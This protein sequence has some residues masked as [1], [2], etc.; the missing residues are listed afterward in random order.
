MNRQLLA[1]GSPPPSRPNSTGTYAHAHLPCTPNPYSR[2]SAE[3][4]F[5]G[6]QALKALGTDPAKAVPDL[7]PAAESAPHI[8]LHDARFAASLAAVAACK[9]AAALYTAAESLAHAA[10]A[11]PTAVADVHAAVAT[12]ATLKA[13][14]I[15]IKTP[16]LSAVAPLF[17][18][19]TH[20][21]GL[22][23]P[24]KSTKLP[25]FAATGQAYWTIAHAQTLG[26][27]LAT[28]LE[29][30]V[31]QALKAA[32]PD[33][34]LWTKGDDDALAATALTLSGAAALK[35][36]TIAAETVRA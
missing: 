5:Y 25:T 12:L 14:G 18:A 2:K 9:R 27:T 4:L 33:G 21:T 16:S 11:N 24:S 19:L 20:S 29:A 34:G 35:A 30:G 8:D 15:K 7:C 17:K 23:R 13:A 36:S 32:K 10:L 28:G 22:L 26:S 1:R 31:G 6:A 3:H